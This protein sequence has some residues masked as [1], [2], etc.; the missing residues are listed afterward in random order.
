MSNK[1]VNRRLP[2]NADLLGYSRQRLGIG[3]IWSEESFDRAWTATL[4]GFL[5]LLRAIELASLSVKDVTFGEH[6]GAR[7]VRIFIRK[8]KTDKRRIR[9]VPKLGR[10]RRNVAPYRMMKSWME[11]EQF[12]N[13]ESLSCKEG[14]L[15]LV[16]RLVKW[17]VSG[18]NLPSDRFPIRSLRPCGATCLYHSGVD[19]EC[20]RR[21]GRG[22]PNAFPLYPTLKTR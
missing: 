4:I 21:F 16:T 10:N 13:R 8:P 5:F 6:D 9:S 19:L 15:G 3:K 14:I 1:N 12:P 17:A 22:R 18:H 2:L 11:G 7:Y 20:I